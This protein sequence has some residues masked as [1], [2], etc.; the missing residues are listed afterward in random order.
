MVMSVFLKNAYVMG[1][2]KNQLNET[3]VMNTHSV[4]FY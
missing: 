2:H 1:I 3:V 4:C